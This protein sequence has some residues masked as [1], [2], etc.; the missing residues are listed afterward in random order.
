MRYP[1]VVL[2]MICLIAGGPLHAVAAQEHKD[3]TTASQTSAGKAAASAKKGSGQSQKP[4]TTF[5]PSERI[6]ADS[7][8]S[9]PV[10][11]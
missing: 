2:I 1:G 10:D 9:F 6:R 4:A 7:A 3:A 5:K 11:I 8:V